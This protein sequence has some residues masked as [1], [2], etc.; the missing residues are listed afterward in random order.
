MAICYLGKIMIR[1]I[2]EKNAYFSDSILLSF[3]FVHLPTLRCLFYGFPVFIMSFL[4][5]Y[6]SL[7]SYL[8]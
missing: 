8:Y 4:L 2:N 1:N 7:F 3:S 5:L 6:F